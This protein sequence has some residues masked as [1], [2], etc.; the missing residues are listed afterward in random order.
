MKSRSQLTLRHYCLVVASLTLAC[1]GSEESSRETEGPASTSYDSGGAGGR[2]GDPPIDGSGDASSAS[3]RVAI[4]IS[5]PGTSDLLLAKVEPAGSGLI[6]VTHYPQEFALSIRHARLPVGFPTDGLSEE[7]CETV[8]QLAAVAAGQG[9]SAVLARQRLRES[10]VELHLDFA[11]PLFAETNQA[12]QSA[13]RDA[14]GTA[15]AYELQ[16][17]IQLTDL[18]TRLDLDAGAI[19]TVMGDGAELEAV[20]DADLANQMTTVGLTGGF[21]TIVSARDLVCDLWAKRARIIFTFRAGQSNASYIGTAT[22]S[23]LEML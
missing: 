7:F 4:S 8:R 2:S 3:D 12:L 22:L 14:G 13:A 6:Q 5:L 10:A 18:N 11:P 9:D 23:G 20:I 16:N 21:K 19:V 1:S 15:M 17:P